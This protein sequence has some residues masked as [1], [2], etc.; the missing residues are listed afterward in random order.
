MPS[1]VITK[2]FRC[3]VKSVDEATGI[4]DMLI[5]L[6]T[7]SEDRTFGAN[8][9]EV[10]KVGAFDKWLPQFRKRAV[11][12]ADHTYT[13]IRKQIGEFVDLVATPGGLFGKPKYYIGQGNAEADWAFN[14]A[15]KGMAAYSVSFIP[16]DFIRGKSADDPPIT[17]TECELVEI[18]HVVVPMNRDTIQERRG[19]SFNPVIDKLYDDVLA[20]DVIVDKG[21]ISYHK[22]PMADV[23]TAWD[24]GAETK[25]AEVEDLKKMCAYSDGDGTSKGDYHLPH[26]KCD[27]KYTTVWKGVAAAA[28]AV[29]GARGADIPD[30]VLKGVKAHLASHYKDF[31]KGVPP[32]EKDG[33]GMKQSEI[34]DELD[35][36]LKIVKEGNLNAENKALLDEICRLSGYDNPVNIKSS[37]VCI[38]HAMDACKLAMDTMQAHDKCHQQAFAVHSESIIK[39]YNGLKGML[40]NDVDMPEEAMAEKSIEVANIDDLIARAVEKI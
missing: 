35:Y 33:K 34:K 15:S 36:C 12:V 5:P 30:N 38:Q 9:G 10:I 29:Q 39:C 20:S 19:K 8:G 3:I 40:S 7:P 1:N 25:K 23:G 17:Y 27:G 11:L 37:K 13:D 21:V 28:A 24:A 14:I 22:Y 31:D 16:Y 32:W 4:I 2:T 18:S 6:S 26:H